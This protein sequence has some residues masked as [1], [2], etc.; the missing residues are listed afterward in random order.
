M[1]ILI[2][3]F[4]TRAVAESAARGGYDV[5]T[6]DYFG[7]RDQKELV[8]NYSLMRDF[9]L[10]FSAEALLEASRSLS[11]EAVTYNSSL[12]N[13]PEVVEALATGHVLLGNSPST[14]RR[15]RDWDC[16]RSLCREENIPH[17]V[18]LLPGEEGLAEGP[19]PWA[20]SELRRWVSKPARSGGGHEI[21]FWKGD[22]LGKGR[23]LQEWIAGR[24]CSAAFVAD[25]QRCVLLGLTEQLIGRTELGARGFTWCGNILPLGLPDPEREAV[26][27]AVREMAEKLTRAFGL[28]GV[29]GVDFVLG[30]KDKE[31][32]D[33]AGLV[34][35]LVEVNPRYTAS[36]EL[37][38]WAYGLNVFDLHVRSFGGALPSF[39][40][41]EALRQPGFYGKGIVYA[42]QD[43]VMPETAGWRAQ[44]R[45]DVPFPGEQIAAH[46]PICT[47]LVRGRTRDECWINLQ[48]AAEMVWQEV[49]E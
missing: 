17:P 7:D 15:V 29:N 5:V 42:R 37:V 36:M 34:P 24:P 35:Y 44:G 10:G 18:T 31:K 46:H 26:L 25:G 22:P 40:L 4:S 20:C 6:L 38:E 9:Q 12:E 16:L 13:H 49:S 43:V 27:D 11:F 14:L 32:G 21:R 2:V 39:S 33:E 30:R 1:R 41:E 28:R 47:V 48:E 8:E 3:G 45:R 23:I 19:G